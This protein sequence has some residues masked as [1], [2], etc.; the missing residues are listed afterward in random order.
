M[1]TSILIILSVF[2]WAGCIHTKVA[3]Q[4]PDNKVAWFQD[5]KFGLFIH[6]GVYS[7]LAGEWKGKSGYNEF[8][9]LGAK[10]PIVEYEEVAKTLN[11]VDFNAEAWVLAAKNAGMK[12]MVITSKHHEGFAMFNSPSSPYNIVN[13]TSFKRDPIKELAD[14]CKKLDVKFGVYY[15][16]GRDWHDPDVP[17]NWPTKAGR[18]NT[19]DFPDEDAKDFSKYFER[20]VK[21]QVKE[22]IAQY[23]PAILWFDTPELI[24]KEQSRE[25]KELIVKLDPK[26][27]VNERI[28]NHYGDY[29]ILEQKGGDKII[30]GCW[31]TC[32]TMSKNWGYIKADTTFKSSEKLIGILVD[33][34]SK[35]GNLLLN[36]G[37]TAEGIIRPQNLSRMAEIGKWLAVNGEAVYGTKP[38]KVFGENA[39]SAAYKSQQGFKAEEKD[40]VFDGTP[41]DVVQDIRFTTRKND[42]YVIAR[43]WRQKEVTV[44]SLIT[45]KYQ[46]KSIQLLGYKGTIKWKQTVMETKIELPKQAINEI[47]VYVFKVKLAENGVHK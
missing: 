19:W 41:K 23:H 44:K 11:P 6:W 14:A 40:A 9:M 46:I 3:A 10:I 39:D 35:G 34:V 26:C 30:P 32:I 31:E 2:L 16:L 13:F 37:P 28:G 22:L 7:K 24:S 15:S 33:A 17:T 47:P 12:Y 18:S 36:V 4:I 20:K 38:W 8:V 42:L 21:P 43:S 1:K 29:D 5:A 27:I 25:L 45:N